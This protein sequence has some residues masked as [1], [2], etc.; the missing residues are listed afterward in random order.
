MVGLGLLGQNSQAPVS[1]GDFE[2]LPHGTQ[3][4]RGKRID[5][6]SIGLVSG[7]V[8]VIALLPR[9]RSGARRWPRTSPKSV[10][11]TL[12]T[13]NHHD[14]GCQWRQQSSE[15]VCRRWL[16]AAS[17]KH[18]HPRAC[19]M[20]RRWMRGVPKIRAGQ[21]LSSAA[22]A[23]LKDGAAAPANHRAPPPSSAITGA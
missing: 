13:S 6:K 19:F 16:H 20:A 8:V 14:Q 21:P 23:K 2:W 9:G 7:R 11:S 3:G 4:E 18:S 10:V 1:R 12:P 15:E 17:M 5:Q 22:K